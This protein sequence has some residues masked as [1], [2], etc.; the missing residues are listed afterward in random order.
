VPEHAK[1]QR[2]DRLGAKPVG[3]RH[4]RQRA[5]HTGLGA[6]LVGQRQQQ[7]FQMNRR[8]RVV[9]GGSRGAGDNADFLL[10][11]H[12]DQFA[13]GCLAGPLPQ[14]DEALGFQLTA[15]QRAEAGSGQAEQMVLDA[16]HLEHEG[17]AQH[18]TDG[19]GLDVGALRRKPGAAAFVPIF[20]QFAGRWVFH[21][22]APVTRFAVRRVPGRDRLA[23]RLRDCMGRSRARAAGGGSG[24]FA[25]GVA[26]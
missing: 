20:E 5:Q 26:R 11:H 14:L 9:G 24:G 16:V 8:E 13:D 15:K 1:S 10:H 22:V 6:G 7:H 19:A 12:R 2:P 21:F 25:G 4:R 3:S 17:V 23:V 18:M